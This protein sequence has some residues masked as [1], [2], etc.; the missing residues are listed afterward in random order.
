[1]FGRIYTLLPV[2]VYVVLGKNMFSMTAEMKSIYGRLW[3]FKHSITIMEKSRIE[4]LVKEDPSYFYNIL[5]YAYALNVLDDFV[6]NFEK[7]YIPTAQNAYISPRNAY[8][9]CNSL[10]NTFTAMAMATGVTRTYSKI[11][12]SGGRGG[13]SGGFSGGGFGGGGSHGR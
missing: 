13:F 7:I 9:L 11:G 8:M 2:V 3:G 6:K 12:M 10:N 1:M 4:R 5:P